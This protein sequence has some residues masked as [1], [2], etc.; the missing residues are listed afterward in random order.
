[1]TEGIDWIARSGARAKGRRP[2]FFDEPALDRLYSLTLALA[3]EL[4]ATRERLDTVER[5]LETGG[6]LRREDIEAY[7]PD[8]AAG[9]ERG[10]STRAYIA[11]IM[12]GFQ[13]EVEAM[14]NPDP[15]IMDWVEK[16]STP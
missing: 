6:T 5:L 3:S 1:M 12:R 15:P 14:E 16:L 13:Q 8:R 2:A 7:A 4:S 11:R 10:E 9:E